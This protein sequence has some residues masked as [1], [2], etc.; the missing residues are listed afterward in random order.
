[1]G[2][3]VEAD[4]LLEQSI[5]S[6]RAAGDHPGLIE[7]LTL[8]GV[9][10]LESGNR[11]LA[12]QALA[13]ALEIAWL[14]GSN[15]RLAHLLEALAQFAVSREPTAC[16]RLAATAHQLR[17]SLGAAP[18]PTEQARVGRC[19]EIAKRLLGS[20]VYADIWLDAQAK[21]LEAALTEA[22]HL[23]R[24]PTAHD[25]GPGELADDHTLSPREREVVMLVARG[26]T[27]PQ[28]AAELIISRK[29]V[30]SHISHVLNKLGLNSRV[31]I[32]TWAMRRDNASGDRRDPG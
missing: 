32:A 31:Q 2:A 25:A 24:N 19:L 29:T 14:F 30:E 27:N 17:I 13:E 15:M 8:R 21:P 22:R 23:L 1:V 28:I 20:Q 12:T 10:A 6:E 18:V 7:S 4:R 9:V 5:A 16:V 26:F 11:Q 3:Y